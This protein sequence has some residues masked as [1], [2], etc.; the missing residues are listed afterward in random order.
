MKQSILHNIKSYLDSHDKLK[1]QIHWLLVNDTQPRWWTKVLV[2]RFIHHK[3]NGAR[4]RSSVRMDTFP[5]N[6]FSIGQ[7]SIIEDFAVINNGV[8][9]VCIGSHV[10]VGISNV[11]IGPVKIGDNVILAQ[12]V[13][14]SGLNHQYNDISQ[15]IKN[16]KVSTDP[17]TI[18]Q[19]TWIG[20]NV[21]I[22]AGVTIGEHAV[23]G[24]GSVVTKSIPPYHVAVGNPARVVKR[25]DFD[26]NEWVKVERKEKQS[27]STRK[28]ITPV[29]EKAMVEMKK[30]IINQ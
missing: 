23:I 19:N 25:F 10:R 5:F 24:A 29:E 11:I 13:V 3:G 18:G 1:A 22:T 12:N 17:I 9:G 16:Q 15:P 27:E 8:G 4:I 21:S 30:S 2:N 14:M 28:V 7:Q 6:P 20:A 26:T